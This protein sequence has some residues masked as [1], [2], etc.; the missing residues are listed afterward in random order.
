MSKLFPETKH[1]SVHSIESHS[2]SLSLEEPF[3]GLFRLFH[4]S[5]LPIFFQSEF[6]STL[7]HYTV[8]VYTARFRCLTLC[9][10]TFI[11]NSVYTILMVGRGPL[12]RV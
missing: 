4:F 3:L 6:D 8:G 7:K 12:L 5:S 1:V 10:E 11:I 2:Q 9:F